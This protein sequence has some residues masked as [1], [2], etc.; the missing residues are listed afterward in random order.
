MKLDDSN[1][2]GNLKKKTKQ[3]MCG[4][5]RE[6]ISANVVHVQY[7]NGFCFASSG[8]LRFVCLELKRKREREEDLSWRVGF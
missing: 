5:W 4:D 8:K 3:K 1:L 7:F 6:T 2:P